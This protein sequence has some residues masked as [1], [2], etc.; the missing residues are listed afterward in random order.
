MI[1]GNIKC[2]YDQ[3]ASSRRTA[4]NNGASDKIPSARRLLERVSI[5]NTV[6][7]F[8]TKGRRD[9]IANFFR[10]S[11]L[12]EPAYEEVVVIWR[13]LRKKKS[14]TLSQRFPPKWLYKVAE[15]FDVEDRLPALPNR[16]REEVLNA[17]LPPLEIRAFDDVP[18]AN[19]VS[20]LPKTKLVFRP[21]DAI[22]FD[23]VSI[24]SFLAVAASLRY[25]SLKLDL[26]AL[27]SLAFF[28][29]RTFFRYSNKYAR[30]DLLV[31]KFLTSKISHRGPGALKYLL[32]EAN[33]NR[34]LRAVLVRD[35]L[36]GE[37]LT[38]N[39]VDRQGNG[40][41]FEQGRAYVN[42]KSSLNDSQIN[43]DIT[44]AL[45]DLKK[46]ELIEGYDVKEEQKAR[47]SMRQLWN[48]TF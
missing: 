45:E 18:M 14:K 3:T 15:V 4:M 12:V 9:L 44:A 25:D 26:L 13:P 37:Y 16:T 38:K 34:A 48:D 29:V 42:K 11:T 24:I 7:F 27:T 1:D 5:Q 39:T 21:A 41:L 20:V 43:V 35:W 33:T 6:N 28:A 47:D 40:T 8:S 10:S 36:R 17:G 31:N 46:L 2:Q 22:V 32:A 23:L 30:Y 19:V